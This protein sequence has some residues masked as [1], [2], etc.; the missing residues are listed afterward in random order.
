MVF[1]GEEEHGLVLQIIT[2]G[3]EG[4]G[5]KELLT[6]NLYENR[7]RRMEAGRAAKREGIGDLGDGDCKTIW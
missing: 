4:L 2:Y 3:L 5:Q 1:L 7:G 6:L